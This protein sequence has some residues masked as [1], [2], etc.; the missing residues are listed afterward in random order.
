LFSVSL[1]EFVGKNAKRVS[2]ILNMDGANRGNAAGSTVEI[3]KPFVYQYS[4]KKNY[5]RPLPSNCSMPKEE[6]GDWEHMDCEENLSTPL[7]K[8]KYKAVPHPN[9]VVREMRCIEGCGPSAPKVF[10]YVPAESG[11]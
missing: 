9:R 4:G 2:F 8:V 7:S 6:F 10:K 5:N 1:G 11:C 3:W